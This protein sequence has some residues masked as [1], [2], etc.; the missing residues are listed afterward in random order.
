M[1]WIIQ[2][3]LSKIFLSSL[4][5]PRAAQNSF[6]GCMPPAGRVFETSD[7]RACHATRF[8]LSSSVFLPSMLVTVTVVGVRSYLL[9]N[10]QPVSQCH[11]SPAHYSRHIHSSVGGQRHSLLWHCWFRGRQE[12]HPACKNWA[13]RCRCGPERGVDCLHMVQLMPLP[14]QNPIIS[15]LIS[16]RVVLPFRYRLSLVVLEKRPL[17]GCSSSSSKLHNLFL[18]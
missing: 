3:L 9:D 11:V 15:C 10:W 16:S 17:S 13:I 14:S 18:V 2:V 4:T 5:W 7:L 8:A 12:E 6:A 1:K